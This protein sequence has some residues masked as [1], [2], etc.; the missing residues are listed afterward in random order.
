MQSHVEIKGIARVSGY[1]TY[2]K[3]TKHTRCTAAL[4]AHGQIN[5]C[6]SSQ[7][8]NEMFVAEKEHS[9]PKLA[10]EV[11]WTEKKKNPQKEI[12]KKKPQMHGTVIN[13]T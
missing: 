4:I 2:Q 1:W 12:K 5:P 3:W 9:V 7:C 8:L 10:D 11:A 6:L 13:S